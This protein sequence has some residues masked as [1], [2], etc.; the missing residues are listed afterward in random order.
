MITTVTMNPCIDRKAVINEFRYGGINRVVDNKEEPAGKGIN[1]AVAYNSLGGKT[2]C[3]GINYTLGG[4]LIENLLDDY[5]IEHDFV[6]VEGKLRTNLKIFDKSKSVITEINESGFP[7]KAEDIDKLKSRLVQLYDQ[8][9]IIVL[10]GS[11]PKGVPASIYGDL[12][13]ASKGSKARVVLD[14]EGQLLLEGLKAK[15]FMVKPNLYELE[16]ALGERLDGNEEIVRG[17][18]KILDYGVSIVVVSMGES[19][20]VLV[21]DKEALFTPALSVDVK[22][23]V[24][25]GDCMVAAM[26]LC[27]ENG[28]SLKDM[29]IA[30]TAAAASSI[31][32]EGTQLCNRN[33]YESLLP[34]VRVE[35]L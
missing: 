14:A 15:P 19:G 2:Y 25:A 30:G 3:T 10:S 5:K 24:G 29:A 8:S 9:S 18:R 33:N 26:C 4:E 32:H 12:I 28:G 23:T 20:S 35:Y 6:K 27:L 13:R 1:V 22:N 17:A 11:V 31:C 7:V 34:K 21:T 16:I